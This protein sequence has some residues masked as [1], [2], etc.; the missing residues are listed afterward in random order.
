M[1]RNTLFLAAGAALIGILPAHADKVISPE[2]HEQYQKKLFALLDDNN[3]GKVSE[4][5]FAVVV[6]WDDF[7]RYDA[8]SDGKVSKAEYMRLTDDKDLYS[9]LDPEGKGHITFK[10]CFGSK[11]VIKELHKK[12]LD[13]L[14]K[15]GNKPT[16]KYIK[17]SDLPDVT[18]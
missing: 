1:I 13:L 11:T 7:K 2:Q 17:L 18:P 15:T 4:R 16:Q 12:W 8:D 14:K 5:E 9:E 3:D 6:L 10:D